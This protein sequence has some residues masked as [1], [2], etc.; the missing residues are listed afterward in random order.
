MNYEQLSQSIE[1][2][3]P[4]NG[5]GYIKA[6]NTRQ[7]A[8]DIASYVND[9][10]MGVT[11]IFNT[12]FRKL[13]SNEIILEA[14]GGRKIDIIADSTNTNL[15]SSAGDEALTTVGAIKTNVSSKIPT[16]ISR[17]QVDATFVNSSLQPLFY[18]R[19]ASHT[20]A[21]LMTAPDKI[22][23]D[24]IN[25]TTI[26]SIQRTLANKM[27]IFSVSSPFSIEGSSSGIKLLMKTDVGQHTISGIID[28]TDSDGWVH[29]FNVAIPTVGAIQ[30]FMYSNE[31]IDRMLTGKQDSFSVNSPLY[32]QG[33]SSGIELL[34][35]TNIGQNVISGIIDSTDSDGWIHANNGAIPTVGA[36]QTFM[37]SNDDID[38][39]LAEKQRSLIV[40]SPFGTQDSSSGTEL[41][42]KTTT[43]TVINAICGSD[44]TTGALDHGGN[45][46][47]PTVDAVLYHLSNVQN[48]VPTDISRTQNDATF[49]NSSHQPLF[50]LR[51][52]SN[53]LAGL[54][55]A[56]DKIKLNGIP[57]IDMSTNMSLELN[58]LRTSPLSASTM[59]KL[60][61]IRAAEKEIVLIWG[62]S[63]YIQFF[64][65]QY[66]GSFSGYVFDLANG[67]MLHITAGP[68]AP[69]SDWAVEINKIGGAVE[70]TLGNL[71][72]IGQDNMGED[73]GISAAEVVL[74]TSIRHIVTLTQSEFDALTTYDPNTEYNVI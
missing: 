33:S 26:P 16:D 2:N 23:L 17:A 69:S 31:T 60:N 57:T 65:E 58:D 50:Y 43:N 29:A 55:T 54:M 62:G 12:P 14:F 39:M 11:L 35:K 18:L 28:S 1:T 36:I 51:Q 38:R 73:S 66:Q 68:A 47:I 64:V 37:Y 27:D 45:Q 61:N 41:Y 34:M 25:D 67:E 72:E 8:Y 48:T 24:T 9:S 19:Q 70:G 30:T 74:S 71:V 56:A 42:L 3:M 52:A 49:V 6:S 63:S 21:G 4:T 7:V 53:S 15:W 5:V 46:V 44:D 13:T 10:I 59:Q 40:S 22:I 20:L 32:I